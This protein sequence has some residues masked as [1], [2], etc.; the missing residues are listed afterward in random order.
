MPSPSPR[1]VLPAAA[2]ALSAAVVRGPVRDAVVLGAHRLGLYLEVDGSVLP[3]VPSDAVALPTALRLGA[4]STSLPDSPLPWGVGAGDRVR[5]GGGRVELPVGDVVAVRT[6]R[7]ARVRRVASGATCPGDRAG[8]E[9]LLLGATAGCDPWLAPATTA[10][11]I[12][13]LSSDDGALAGLAG[14]VGRGRGLTP[15]G[16]DALAGALL[17]AHALRTS[18]PLVTAVRARLGTTTAVSAALLAAATD[19]FAARPVVAL[20]D[21][22]VL[23]H[24]GATSRAL[25]E[26]VAIGHTSGR[27]LVT[28]VLAALRT[29]ATGEA[30]TTTQTRIPTGR[31]AA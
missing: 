10:V 25:P 5:V 15:S 4:R 26:V 12:A 24:V 27:D 9:A 13:S 18:R 11:L 1:S 8:V 20:V 30:T 21:A 6:W 23:G 16:D 22:V 19:G 31:S 17:V 2:S 29:A 14:L 28:G 7:P 3:V